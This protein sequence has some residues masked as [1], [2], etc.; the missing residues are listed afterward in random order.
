MESYKITIYGI[1]QG[2]GFRPFIYNL[3]NSLSLK[4]YVRN[5][6]SS[7]CIV[8]QGDINNIHQFIS[9]IAVKAPRNASITSIITQKIAIKLQYNNFV[10]KKSSKDEINLIYSA[11]PQDLAI[12]S[13]CVNE[14]ESSID[15]RYNYAFI[16]C[17]NCGPRYSIIKNL[18]YD[19]INT[20]MSEFIMCDL[21]QDEYDNPLDRRF[22][23]QPNSCHKCG[24]SLSLFDANGVQVCVESGNKHI[25]D[26]SLESNIN[27]ATI[28]YARKLIVEGKILALKGIGGFNL[29]CNVESSVIEHLRAL[30]NRPTKPFA[31]MFADIV[32]L[33][34]Y[35]SL[36]SQEISLLTSPMS[37]IVLLKRQKNITTLPHNIAPNLATIGVVLAYSPLHKLLLQDLQTPIIF[38]S[39]N[40]SGEPLVRS[41]NE[42]FSK[43]TFD[44]L[45]DFNREIVN[46]IDDSVVMLA[47]KQP[48]L[49]RAARGYYP[50][51]LKIPF[52]SDKVVLALGANQKSQIALFYRDSVVIS[53]YIGDLESVDSIN[54]FNATI[55]LF[56]SLYNLSPSIILCDKHPAYQSSKI[57]IELATKYNAKVINIYHHRAH[58]YSCLLDN[59]VNNKANLALDSKEPILGVIF[60]GTGLG[61]DGAIW[62]GEFFLNDNISF[63]RVAHFK[64][65][66]LLG[67]DN[68]IKDIKK[69]ALGMLFSVYG[70]E[71]PD[72]F[73]CEN[74][75][76]YYQMFKNN[77]NSP[78][79]SSAGRIFDCVAYLCGALKSQ[80]YEGESGM[81]LEALYDKNIKES[82]P[83]VI[84]NGVISLDS[85]MKMIVE[86]STNDV[87]SRRII[88]S[89]F[90]NTLVEII[91]H[92][93]RIYNAKVV[94]SGGVFQNRILCDRIIQ[95]LK[96][97][98]IEFFIHRT[99]S[100]ND[101]GIAFGQIGAYVNND[102]TKE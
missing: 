76:I 100:P 13:D 75:E 42:A 17:T 69:I 3:A 52:V 19:R 82:Y 58:L 84:E 25:D 62:G 45:L 28:H 12:C 47:Y 46:P 35:F 70:A 29:V 14:L 4:G 53:P 9:Q 95:S 24:I 89:K 94:F 96:R 11:I 54:R 74:M 71:I 87:Q 91:T 50:L 55:K 6:G 59:A 72:S 31:I 68:A 81:V 23:A 49:L 33:R 10:I 63:R 15:R 80:S 5:M 18:P 77:L 44:Y 22:H 85:A 61:E 86:S 20:S 101:G 43:I 93:A 34:R 88:A 99:L 51:A 78:L 60:D 73:Q 64:Y 7:L 38:T 27:M 21:C 98:N 39:A 48:I 37:P 36:T 65:F 56:L 83:F 16:N 2:V 8:V 30:K 67:G 97:Y 41:S 79:T 26:C 40:L 57:A 32:V 1:V 66:P 92:M 102:I 90:I